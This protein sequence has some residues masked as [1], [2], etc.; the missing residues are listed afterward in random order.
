MIYNEF[1]NSIKDD[2]ISSSYLF[3]GAEEYMM[4]IA[5]EDLKNKFSVLKYDE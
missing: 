2:N 5:I 1:M 3:I 4:N